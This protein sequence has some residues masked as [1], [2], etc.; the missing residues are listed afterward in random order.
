VVSFAAQPVTT[1]KGLV[2][3]YSV[4]PISVQ[5]VGGTAQLMGFLNSLDLRN[6]EVENVS[7]S[8]AEGEESYNISLDMMVHLTPRE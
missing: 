2:G 1:R 6:L 8:K 5:S 3:S 4:L 7:L